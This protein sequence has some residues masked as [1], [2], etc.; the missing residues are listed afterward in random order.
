MLTKPTDLIEWANTDWNG[1]KYGQPNKVQ[2]TV[3]KIDLGYSEDEIPSRNH[4]NWLLNNIHQWI[5]FLD[6]FVKVGTGSPN[7]VVTGDIG[8]LYINTSG[9][10]GTTLYVKESGTATNTGW[11]AK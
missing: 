11:V 10:A 8:N 1:T 2:P 6:E 4:L 9:G 3:E 5:G 7:G